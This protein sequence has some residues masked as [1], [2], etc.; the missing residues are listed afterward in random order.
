MSSPCPICLW[1]RT[2]G[3]TG[4]PVGMRKT[5]FL[6]LVGGATPFG[7]IQ[8]SPPNLIVEF[9]YSRENQGERDVLSIVNTSLSVQ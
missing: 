7:V 8:V 5:G 9:G 6:A 1:A 3:A 4:D 2:L